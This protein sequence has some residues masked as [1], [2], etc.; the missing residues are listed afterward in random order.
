MTIH[1]KNDKIKRLDRFYRANLINSIVGIKQASLIGTISSKK[2]TNLAIFSS[3]IH[4]GS[5]PALI[6]IFSR[7]NTKHPKQTMENILLNKQF[8]INHVN[9]D[10]LKES[11]ATSYKFNKFISEFSKCNLE[12]KYIENFDAP[13]VNESEIAIGLE[14]LNDYKIIENGVVMIIGEIQHII[15]KNSNHIQE[16]GELNF[17]SA[18]S[19]GVSGNNTYY[20]L[21]NHNTLDYVTSTQ[22]FDPE[23]LLD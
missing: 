3:G 18:Q 22:K 8:T 20:E 21:K 23:K 16:N 14:Y 10:I 9:L 1:Y 5:N 17:Q 19:V 12:E 2:T 15:I 7:P 13:F 6:G 4:L 11:H